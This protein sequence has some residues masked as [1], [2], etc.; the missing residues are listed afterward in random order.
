MQGIPYQ[1]FF[2]KAW[3]I[4]GDKTKTFLYILYSNGTSVK[5][6]LE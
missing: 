2:W 1:I 6:S 4:K 5:S 3:G